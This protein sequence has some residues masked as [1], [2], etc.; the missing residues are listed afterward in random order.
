[1]DHFDRLSPEDQA[2]VRSYAKGSIGTGEVPKSMKDV[3]TAVIALAHQTTTDE[4][5]SLQGDLANVGIELLVNATM[6]MVVEIMVFAMKADNEEGHKMGPYMREAL[7]TITGE[8]KDK[9]GGV[10]ER[11]FNLVDEYGDRFPEIGTKRVNALIKAQVEAM[12]RAR[13]AK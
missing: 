2:E 11:M 5:R 4:D 13:Q 9:I 3:A 6:A 1:M 10:V 12:A 7:S 8:A